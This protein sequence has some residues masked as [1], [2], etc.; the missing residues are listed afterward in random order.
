MIKLWR[1]NIRGRPWN[2]ID[3]FVHNR[4][5]RVVEGGEW[6]DWYTTYEGV[7]QGSVLA[8]VLFTLSI[9]GIIK[10]NNHIVNNCENNI[11]QQQYNTPTTT[12]SDECIEQ[13]YADDIMVYPRRYGCNQVGTTAS[14]TMVQYLG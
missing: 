12:L 14:I 1:N 3:Q 2:Q 11:A 13:L 6:S 5:I 8:P 9:N 10:S 4:K 7:P